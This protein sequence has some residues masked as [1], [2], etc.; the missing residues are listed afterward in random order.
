MSASALGFFAANEA[1]VYNETS[2]CLAQKATWDLNV[3]RINF[4]VLH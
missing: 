4:D 3:N 1:V 2:N